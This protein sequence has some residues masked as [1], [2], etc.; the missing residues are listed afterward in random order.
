[1]GEKHIQ[2]G[3]GTEKFL[4]VGKMKRL[5]RIHQQ[6]ILP[7][8]GR[9]ITRRP[10]KTVHPPTEIEA[11]WTPPHPHHLIFSIKYN[12]TEKDVTERK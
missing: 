3:G 6:I 11:G 2:S 7:Q 1:K 4:S 10:A 9:L 8:T 12:R 5:V